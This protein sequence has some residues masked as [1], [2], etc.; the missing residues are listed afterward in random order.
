MFSACPLKMTDFAILGLELC[1]SSNCV[2][3]GYTKI[4]T[5]KQISIFLKESISR[6][7]I[8]QYSLYILFKIGLP[9]NKLMVD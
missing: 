7:K 9:E 1:V 4:S 6:V 8:F 3:P 2:P 5:D